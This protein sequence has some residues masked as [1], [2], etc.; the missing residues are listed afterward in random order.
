MLLAI[1]TRHQ[2]VCAFIV[3][4]VVLAVCV[5]Y[6]YSIVSELLNIY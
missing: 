6:M 4:S 5:Y 3:L 2:H 1:P